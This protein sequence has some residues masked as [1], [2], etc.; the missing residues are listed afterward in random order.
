MANPHREAT[1]REKHASTLCLW[2]GLV[3]NHPRIAGRPAPRCT[4]QCACASPLLL[5]RWSSAFSA[6]AR[7]SEM[8]LAAAMDGRERGT[9]MCSIHKI[10][11]L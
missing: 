3:Q 7:V 5:P 2:I 10:A 1:D 6:S 4:A 8:R 11:S 9:M